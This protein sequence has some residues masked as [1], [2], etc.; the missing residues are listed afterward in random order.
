MINRLSK[1]IYFRA[2]MPLTN[3][4][5]HTAGATYDDAFVVYSPVDIVSHKLSS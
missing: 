4:L 1:K 2:H 3:L 5:D